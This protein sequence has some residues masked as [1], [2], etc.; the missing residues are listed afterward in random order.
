MSH[1][2]YRKKTKEF[3]EKEAEEQAE[4]SALINYMKSNDKRVSRGAL[5]DKK[6]K[7]PEENENYRTRYKKSRVEE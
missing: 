4:Q 7:R 6:H 3:K 2:H 1:K 5:H